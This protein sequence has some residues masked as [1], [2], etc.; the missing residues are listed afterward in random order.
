MPMRQ[1]SAAGDIVDDRRHVGASMACSVAPGK[2]R[3]PRPAQPSPAAGA[4]PRPLLPKP[5]AED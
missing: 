2:R 4:W 1:L 3:A 5:A